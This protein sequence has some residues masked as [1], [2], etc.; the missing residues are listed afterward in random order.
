MALIDVGEE[1]IDRIGSWGAGFMRVARGN[2]ANDSGRIT[3][4]EIWAATTL[5]GCRVG[6]FYTTNGNTL[7]CRDSVAIGSVTAGS[8]QTFSGLSIVVETG[9]YIG[10]YHTGG[11]LEIDTSGGEGVWYVEGEYIDPDDEATYTLLSA[12]LISLYGTG[13]TIVLHELVVTD[14]IEVGEALVKMPIKIL[15]DGVALSDVLIKNPIKVF[16][17]GIALSDALEKAYVWVRVFTDSIAIGEALERWWTQHY[18]RTFTDSIAFTDTLVKTSVKVLADGIKFTDCLVRWRWLTAI[19]N[20]T[21]RRCTQ[22]SIREQ[23]PIDD[24]NIGI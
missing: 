14:G 15:A 18:E 7:K 11:T 22:P 19:R 13:S 1:A 24:G 12:F 23:D 2:P 5:T 6:T 21:R 4:V 20:L 17:D 3:S 9:D 10:I 16:T 8:K